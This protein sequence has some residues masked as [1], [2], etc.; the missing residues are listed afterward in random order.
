MHFSFNTGYRINIATHR[1]TTKDNHTLRVDRCG[2]ITHQASVYTRTSS[3][4]TCT[5]P[6]GT[7]IS[8]LHT[9]VAAHRSSG[10]GVV[11][12]IEAGVQ[13]AAGAGVSAAVNITNL[14]QWYAYGYNSITIE[15]HPS[16][17]CDKNITYRTN[18]TK[19]YSK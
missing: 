5:G 1:P 16:V 6:A 14:M 8:V 9:T 18:T 19:R 2:E 7:T 12:V 11:T 4:T 3:A 15:F 17:F 13:V 10:R